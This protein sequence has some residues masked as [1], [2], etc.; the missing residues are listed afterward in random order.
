MT[1]PFP[2]MSGQG[3]WVLNAASYFTFVIHLSVCFSNY[4]HRKFISEPQVVR[5]IC[6]ANLHT[7]MASEEFSGLHIVRTF[8]L[9]AKLFLT[10]PNRPSPS[11]CT[12]TSAVSCQLRV[13]LQLYLLAVFSRLLSTISKCTGV[14]SSACY[15]LQVHPRN[16]SSYHTSTVS[17][18]YL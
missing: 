3:G 10:R 18:S 7:T 12:S 16:V 1:P 11:T 9:T 2:L 6:N 8:R 14:L 17:S 5:S 13:R 4:L 15:H